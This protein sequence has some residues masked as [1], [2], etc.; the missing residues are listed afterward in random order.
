MMKFSVRSFF[1]REFMEFI[2]ACGFAA[3]V[4]FVSRIMLNEFMSYSMA[5][6]S[7]YL[8]G[9]V[10][11]FLLCKFL[12]F[13]AAETRRTGRES[14]A[15]VL[16]NVVA[17]LQTLGVSIAL[18]DHLFPRVGW[19]FH[20]RETAHLVGIGVPVFSSYIGHKYF[21]FG[22]TARAD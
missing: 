13:K 19:Q 10:T 7:A 22:S 6:V 12:V 21:S 3:L 11:A 8:I 1:T 15:F 2:A 20:P 9:M 4:N 18:A 5:I 16:V 17:V 14:T